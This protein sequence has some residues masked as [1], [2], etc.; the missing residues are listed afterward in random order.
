MLEVPA[1]KVGYSVPA[2]GF[3]RYRRRYPRTDSAAS[4]SY[5]TY[6]ALSPGTGEP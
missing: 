6:S 1:A 3:Y 2:E 4:V 5:A